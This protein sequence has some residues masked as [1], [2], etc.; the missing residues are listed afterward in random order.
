[1]AAPGEGRQAGF[2]HQATLLLSQV[3]EEY[4]IRIIIVSNMFGNNSS[5][6]HLFLLNNVTYVICQNTVNQVLT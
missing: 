4:Y 5:W 1:M 2:S 3:V 6:N